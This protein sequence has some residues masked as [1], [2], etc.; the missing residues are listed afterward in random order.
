MNDLRF[1][2]S[3]ADLNKSDIR[4]VVKVLEKQYLAQGEVV[5]KFEDTIQKKFNVS[6]AVV[7][8]SGTAAL[9]SVYKG[10]GL[11]KKNG[12]ITSPITFLATANAARMCNAPVFFA[13]VDNKTGLITPKNLQDAF[14]RVTFKV[15][16]VVIVHLGGHLCDLEG[17]SKVAKKHNCCIIED[18]CHA[19]GAVY[20]GKKKGFIGSCQ[21]SLA[22]TFSF[23][24]I[25]N[26]TMGEGGAVTT[27][28]LSL[29]NK[30]RLNISHG[31]IRDKKEMINPPKLSPWYYQMIDYGWNYRASEISCA[32][33]L[34]QFKRITKIINKRNV[35][36]NLYKKNLLNNKF[37]VLPEFSKKKNDKGWHLFQLN[38]SFEKLNIKKHEFI[39]YLKKHSI[40]SQ[41]HYIPLVSQPY[42]SNNKEKRYL[43]GAEA[44]YKN[45]ISIPMYTSLN[46]KSIKFISKV[47]NDYF[48][49]II[50]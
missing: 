43:I 46:E 5:K 31:M 9:H 25:K 48:S 22:T 12:I 47:I 37:V 39:K 18:A 19:L 28:D 4:A 27:N 16:A 41:V 45:T 7:C 10:I 21:Y 29:A 30:V 14:R 36:A 13:D 26:I 49:K 24:A 3:R 34:S 6:Q 2:Y 50:L 11:D 20:Y 40:G 23:H 15:K 35:I 33:G 1:P 8:N 42:Y 32:L 38:I 44:F 17:L